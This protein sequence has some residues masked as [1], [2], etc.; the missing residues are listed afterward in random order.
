MTKPQALPFLIPFAAWFLAR[1]GVAGLARAS[2]IGVAVI[3]IL[4]LPFAVEAGPLNYLRNIAAYQDDVF[5][6]LSARAWNVWWLLQEIGAG[7]QMASDRGAVLGPITFRHIGY[8][9][10]GLVSLYVGVKVYRDPQRGH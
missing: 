1:G 5:S 10:A 3:A 9:L 4:W 8:L 6:V 7:G 2:A